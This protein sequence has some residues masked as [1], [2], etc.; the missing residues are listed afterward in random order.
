MPSAPQA[1]A[2]AP[3]TGS[4]PGEGTNA[5]LPGSA[6]LIMQRLSFRQSRASAT[7]AQVGGVNRTAADIMRT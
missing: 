7:L 4:Y 1:F 6:D 2:P 5:N 3:S